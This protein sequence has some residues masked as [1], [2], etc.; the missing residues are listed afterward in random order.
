[1]TVIINAH[2][3]IVATPTGN[4][5]SADCGYNASK[6]FNL[7]ATSRLQVLRPREK[8]LGLGEAV[9][10]N[11]VKGLTVHVHHVH[12]LCLWLMLVLTH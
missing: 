4:Y 2:V 6:E 10:A 11:K 3:L 7:S 1:M 5:Q 12:A 9:P 8:K